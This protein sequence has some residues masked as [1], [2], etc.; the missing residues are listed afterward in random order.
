MHVFDTERVELVTN[1][2]MN[3]ARTQFDKWKVGRAEDTPP[4]SWKCF[5]EAFS[6]CFFPQELK[7]IKVRELLTLNQ[8]TLSFHEYRLKFTQL[9]Y[10]AQQMVAKLR[11]RVSLFVAGLTRPSSK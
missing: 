2:L 6:G 9:Y 3:F 5:E 4:A 1:R 11:S 8:D 7:K 10:Y